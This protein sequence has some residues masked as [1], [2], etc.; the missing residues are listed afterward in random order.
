MEQSRPFQ[1]TLGSSSPS[2]LGPGA[3]E[4]YRHIASDLLVTVWEHNSEHTMPKAFC[5]K[6]AG[7]GLLKV[8]YSTLAKSSSG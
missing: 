1:P 8:Y 6:W 5:I 3:K 4:A 2:V 7:V